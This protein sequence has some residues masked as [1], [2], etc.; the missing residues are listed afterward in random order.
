M[1]WHDDIAE[2]FPERRDDEPESLRNDI[3]DELADHLSCALN[4][5]LLLS[6][7]EQTAIQRV[8]V[9][10]GDPRKIARK[11]WFD[12]MK[13]KLMAQRITLITSILAAVASLAACAM[14]Y[15]VTQRSDT[16]LQAF[17]TRGTQTDEAILARLD[18]LASRPVSV[19]FSSLK[20]RLVVGKKG[21]PPAIGTRAL[22]GR[23]GTG[24]D[25]VQIDRTADES[26]TIDFGLQ[27]YGPYSL[28]LTTPDKQRGGKQVIVKL[29]EALEEEIVCPEPLPKASDAEITIKFDGLEGKNDPRF[30]FQFKFMKPPI[31][32]DNSFWTDPSTNRT[33]TVLHDGL[34]QDWSAATTGSFVASAPVGPESPKPAVHWRA[35]SYCLTSITLYR[36]MSNG[37]KL[38]LVVPFDRKPGTGHFAYGEPKFE[39]VAGK[40]NEWIIPVS[41]EAK[42]VIQKEL[43]TV[44]DSR[45]TP[46]EESP[47][48]T[49]PSTSGT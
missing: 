25:H 49:K 36:T 21:G 19:E 5:E 20:V 33:A 45:P 41:K 29:G 24:S 9:R 16:A 38:D 34:L 3:A 7:N 32:I 27:R 40:K 17:V 2:S 12:S 39:A 30:V 10:F 35:G 46:V 13:E 18:A 14:V 31:V 47:A 1:N 11:L 28:S 6:P 4:R 22:L 43:A 26:G 42:A 48:A 15:L 8:L 44:R 37:Q 23:S